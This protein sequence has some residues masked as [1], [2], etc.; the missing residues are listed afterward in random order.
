MPCCGEKRQQQKSSWNSNQNSS[1]APYSSAR[2]SPGLGVAMSF[3]YLGTG[4]LRVIGPASGRE[5]VFAAPRARV[6]VDARDQPWLSRV[7][8][9][10]LV[11]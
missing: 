7:Q 9:L 2:F 4:H 11:H 8:S 6:E 3:E 5:Y 10:R 1:S